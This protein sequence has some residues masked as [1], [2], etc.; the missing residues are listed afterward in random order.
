[1]RAVVDFIAV[2]ARQRQEG[3]NNQALSFI[4]EL[5]FTDTNNVVLRPGMSVRAEIFTSSDEINRIAVP[6]QAISLEENIGLNQATYSVFI[7]DGGVARKTEVE[8]GIADDE[9]QEVT[10]GLNVGDQII[11]GPDRVLRNLNDGDE[12]TLAEG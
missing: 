11:V 3:N 12:I 4:V 10:A 7:Y 6:I 5:R 9:F 8:V 1:M 2:S